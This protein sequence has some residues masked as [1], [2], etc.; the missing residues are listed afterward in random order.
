MTNY[1]IKDLETLSGVKAHTIRMWEQR[2][3]L[4][5]PKRT[6][7]NI[8]YYTEEDLKFI[9][10]VAFLNR[11]GLKIS[12]IAH[13]T[14]AQ[15]HEK[16]QSITRESLEDATQQ[17]ALTM[18]MMELDAVEFERI[19]N[20]NSETYG[21]EHCI[22]YLIFPFLQKLSLLWITGTINH[23]HEQFVYNI[24]R[25]R[26]YAI[27]ENTPFKASANPKNCILYLLAEENNDIIILLATSF[28]KARNINPLYIGNNITIE[29]LQFV[30]EKHPIDFI[31]TSLLEQHAKLP[32]Y[33]HIEALAT[34]FP[35]AQILLTGYQA[36]NIKEKLNF[37]NVIVFNT[38][39]HFLSY[40]D[41][42]YALIK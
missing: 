31:F 38:L 1:S 18:A 4:L 40:L 27:I 11:K 8:R 3:A 32:I 29:D 7:T 28:M 19:M 14:R 37:P 13:M 20:S 39:V 12:A 25:R 34:T 15:I 30:A 26:L 22:V 24:I 17:Q 36:S 41:E 16:V 21:L 10:N 33:S 35:Q 42:N 2:Y 9:L 6:P 23:V 5:S